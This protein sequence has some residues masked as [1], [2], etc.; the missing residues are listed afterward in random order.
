MRKTL[1]TASLMMLVYAASANAQ[2]AAEKA[3]AMRATTMGVGSVY[4]IAKGY[5]LRTAELVPQEKYSFKP[6]P[7]VRSF[8]A[9]LGHIADSQHMFCTMAEGKPQPSE[10]MGTEKLTDKEA[11]IAELKRSFAHCDAVYAKLTDADLAREVNL[12]GNK[13][14]V[15]AVIT[16]NAS[17]DMEHYGNLVTYM[18]INGIVPP[19][20]QQ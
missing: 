10:D 9:I 17:H 4:Q 8:G 14:N 11:I 5:L 3:S 6:T 12:F 18:R 7:A 19:S 2:E 15:A 1:I 20:S 16:L 13:A